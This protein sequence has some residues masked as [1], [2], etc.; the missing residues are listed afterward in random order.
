M[1]ANNKKRTEQEVAMRISYV[2][3]V[4]GRVRTA[5]NRLNTW[6]RSLDDGKLY[7]TI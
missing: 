4:K 3:T 1:N 6:V 7:K 2:N 5:D